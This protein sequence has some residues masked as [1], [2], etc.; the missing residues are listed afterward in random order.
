M[1]MEES[2][3]AETLAEFQD[4][5][6]ANQNIEGDLEVLESISDEEMEEGLIGQE[7][8]DMVESAELDSG[9]ETNKVSES[10]SQT[11]R[12]DQMGSRKE[13]ERRAL[14]SASI[15]SSISQTPAPSII[16]DE[17]ARRETQPDSKRTETRR[18][19]TRE[20]VRTITHHGSRRSSETR[21][22]HHSEERASHRTTSQPATKRE[23][24]HSEKQE[25]QHSDRE[26]LES[27]FITNVDF[28]ALNIPVQP[29]KV[30]GRYYAQSDRKQHLVLCQWKDANGHL[31]TDWYFEFL[32]DKEKQIR[33]DVHYQ[34]FQVL[35]GQFYSPQDRSATDWN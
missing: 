20:V 34:C 29:R 13:R 21:K 25:H 2:L 23:Q 27:G 9:E 30:V 8:D 14:P 26:I 1:D 35:V 3:A 32:V 24:R 7:I 12:E 19:R 28:R 22:V 33:F 11:S 18:S 6:Q 15:E 4:L 5:L 16:I 10:D 31:K 17:K